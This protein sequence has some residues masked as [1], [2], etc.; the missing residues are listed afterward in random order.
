M[1]K[2]D[3]KRIFGDNIIASD[4][5]G[6]FKH[7]PVKIKYRKSVRNKTSLK[8]ERNSQIKDSLALIRYFGWLHDK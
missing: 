1:V 2:L 6:N 3:I 4:E 8:A 5:F 7:L